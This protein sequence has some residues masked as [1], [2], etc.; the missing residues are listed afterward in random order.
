M[1][2]RR[3][4]GQVCKLDLTIRVCGIDK[5]IDGMGGGECHTLI[6]LDTPSYGKDPSMGIN[7]SLKALP[8]EKG[9]I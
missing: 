3:C 7:E 5:V 4:A 2:T 9:R 6:L 1:G 8:K